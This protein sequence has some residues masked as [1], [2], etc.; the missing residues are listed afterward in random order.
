[1][2]NNIAEYLPLIASK[3]GDKDAILSLQPKSSK[4]KEVTFQQLENLSNAYAI[5]FQKCGIRKNTKTLLMLRPSVEFIAI[6]FAVFKIGAIPILIDPGMGYKKFLKCVNSTKPDAIIAISMVYWVSLLFR[7]TFKK[8]GIKLALGGF[9]PPTIKSLSTVKLSDNINFDIAKTSPEDKAA[10]LFTTG[11]TGPAKGVVYTHKIFT[12]QVEIISSTYGT[13][14]KEIDLPIFPLFALFSIAMGMKCVIP[15]MNPS[16]PATVNP[17]IIIDAI[18]NN[19]ITFS[20]GSPALW[21]TVAN[22]CIKNKI[23]FPSLKKVL[24]AGAPVSEELHKKMKQIMGEGGET[25]IPYGATESLP[26][27]TFNGTEMLAE[28]ANKTSEGKGYCVGYPIT[29]MT[30][31]IIKATNEVISNWN[32]ELILADGEIGEIVVKGPVVTPKY[33]NLETATKLAKIADKD[34]DLWHRM[35]DVGYFDDKKR[36]WFCGRK[37]HRVITNIRSYYSVCCEAIFNKHK[38]VFRTALVG[39]YVNKEYVP[40][41]IVE[42]NKNSF[43]TSNN[44]KEIFINELKKL[45]EEKDFTKDIKTFLFHK[46]FPVDIRHNAKIFR[47]KLTVWVENK[48]NEK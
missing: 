25:L 13:G 15:N 9:S 24:M 40:I 7:K 44:L 4:Y 26:I 32:D 36:L 27:A 18:Q 19:N 23:K 22:Y 42:P 5:E 21:R 43:P 3:Y 46:S 10:I 37:G 30:I 14:Q 12:T 45:G 41:L 38:N 2:I 33:Y 31:K 35:G 20:F 48:L 29:G 47:E 8:I 6:S 39:G 16:R 1:M 17:K 28:T 34:G 11:S